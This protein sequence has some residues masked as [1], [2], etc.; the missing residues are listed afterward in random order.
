M[1][2]SLGNFTPLTAARRFLLLLRQFGPVQ[3]LAVC[4]AM[5]D[6]QYIRAFDRR[7]GVQTSGHV[8]LSQTSF[9][10]ARL[11]DATAYGPV[12]AWGIRKLFKALNLPT[13]L[14]FVDLGSGMGRACILAHEYGFV[15]VTGVELAPELCRVAR[16]NVMNRRR[17]ASGRTPINIIEGD[18]LEYCDSA[19]DDVFFMFRA[20][21]LDFLRTVLDKLAVRSVSQKK[22]LTVIYTERLSWPPSECVTAL[23]YHAAFQEVYQTT[24]W[25]QSFFVFRCG[26]QPA[27]Q[28]AQTSP[29]ATSMSLSET[30]R[31]AQQQA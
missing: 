27:L 5:L 30:A 11:K 2:N 4:A 6:D 9:D 25:G 1:A 28:A 24:S 14:A 21:S 23:A 8:E 18:V 22:S 3:T 17:L 29:A 20:F 16:Q 13:S 12:N 31:R 7:Y 19:T 10:P 15:R 26:M